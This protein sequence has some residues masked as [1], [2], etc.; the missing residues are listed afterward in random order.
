MFSEIN[1][2]VNYMQD[3][4]HTVEKIYSHIYSCVRL[5]HAKNPCIVSS[6]SGSQTTLRGDVVQDAFHSIRSQVWFCHIQ[7]IDLYWESW[8][9]S[10]VLSHCHPSRH[11]WARWTINLT[12]CTILCFINYSSAMIW[13]TKATWR[14]ILMNNDN[15]MSPIYILFHILSILP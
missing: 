2:K 8:E 6:L 7:L 14:R 4:Q 9:Y 1:Y 5:V 10:V 15:S 11:P 3:R 13:I 12:Q